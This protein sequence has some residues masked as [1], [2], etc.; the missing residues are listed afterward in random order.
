MTIEEMVL[1][2]LRHLPDA[3]KAEALRLISSLEDEGAPQ[4]PTRPKPDREKTRQSMRWVAENWREYQGQ[5]VVLD[6][7]RLVASGSDGR[8][9]IRE[10][11]QL[12][13]RVPFLTRV[14][15]EAERTASMGG[16]L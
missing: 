8:A 4:A 14:E 1:E 7:D 16:W 6:G 15:T 11:K 12:G 9:V 3:K 2:K 13:V 10:A 5:W